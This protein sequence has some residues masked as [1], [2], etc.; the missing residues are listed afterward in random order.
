MSMMTVDDF[1]YKPAAMVPS[2]LRTIVY[3]EL[4][5]SP[6]TRKALRTHVVIQDPTSPVAPQNQI[7]VTDVPY[8]ISDAASCGVCIIFY[9]LPW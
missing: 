8:E 9:I 5:K 7:W 6:F 2:C 3:H 4:N 1:H